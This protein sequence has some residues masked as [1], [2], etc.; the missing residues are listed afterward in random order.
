M[1]LRTYNS[2]KYTFIDTNDLNARPQ[3][4]RY[5]R[6]SMREEKV[7]EKRKVFKVARRTEIGSWFQVNSVS[8][9]L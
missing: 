4:R 8:K 9:Q 6:A 5:T 1:A 7:F 3:T 2:F